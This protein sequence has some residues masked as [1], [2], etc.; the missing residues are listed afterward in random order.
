MKHARRSSFWTLLAW[1]LA[2]WIGSSVVAAQDSPPTVLLLPPADA[3]AEVLGRVGEPIELVVLKSRGDQPAVGEELTWTLEDAGSGQLEVLDRQSRAAADGVEA[4]S[5][6]AR[7]TALGPGRHGIR[8]Q[9][10]VEPGCTGSACRLVAHRFVVV[11][12]A[13]P[14]ADRA[15]PG[16]SALALVGGSVAALALMSSEGSEGGAPGARIGIVSGNGQAALANNPLPQPLVVES[17]DN[18]APA[19]NAVITWTASPGVVLSA[20]STATSSSGRTNV[21]V[22]SVGPGPGPATVTATRASDPSASVTFNIAVNIAGLAIVSGDN[23]TTPVDTTTAAPLVVRTT[24]DGS[25]QANVAL[26]WQIL[27]GGTLSG[28]VGTSDASGLAQAF[29]DVGSFPGPIT[30]LVSRVDAPSATQAFTVQAVELRDLVI[31]SGDGQSGAQG[32]PLPAPLA[33]QAL[34]NGVGDAGVTLFW[35]ASG[36]AILSATTTTTDAAGFSN[37]TVTDL[38]LGL[39]PVTVFV[40]RADV[41]SLSAEFTLNVLPPSLALVSGGGQSG[42]AG[43]PAAQPLQVLLLDGAGAPMAGQTVSWQLQ[44]GS[45]VLAAPFSVT[46][47]AGVATVGF[48]Y[49]NVPGPISIRA[50]AFSNGVVALASATGLPPGGMAAASGDGQAGD[51]GDVLAPLTV[52]IVDP[53]PDLSNIQITFV[54][55]SG[56]ATLAPAVALTDAAGQASTTVTLGT[57]PGPVVV[58]AIA[59]GGQVTIF[60]LTINGTLVVTGASTVSGDGQ[61]LAIGVASAPMVV[62]L[63]GNGVPLVGETVQWSTTN[64]TLANATTVTDAN[65]QTSNTVTISSAGAAKVI[66]SFPTVDEF[67]GTSVE[68]NHNGPLAVIPNLAINEASVAEALDAACGVLGGTAALTPDEQDLLDQCNALA[69]ASGTDPATVGPALTAMLPDV[70]QVQTDAGKAAVGAQFENLDGRI[71]QLRSGAPMAKVSF[72]GLN[73]AMSGGQVS[74]AQVGSL[75]MDADPADRPVQES[76]FS[77]WGFFVSGNIGRGESDPTILTPRYDFDINGLTAGLDYRWSDALVVGAALGYTRQDTELA[78]ALGS[79]DTQ[80]FSLSAYSTWYSQREWYLDSVLTLARNQ[81]DH[82]RSIRYTLPGM[83]VD[84]RATASSDGTD[85]SATLTFGRD[86]QRQAWSIGAYARAAYNRLSFDAF[87]ET[88]DSTQPGRGLALRVES[89]DVSGSSAIL[90]G[91][92]AYTHSASW[93]VLVPQL[94]VEWQNDFQSDTEAFRGYFLDDP[95]GTPIL[96]LGD[97]LDNNYLRIGLGLTFVLTEGRSGFI[98]YERL[99]GRSGISQEM[100]SL[101]FRWEF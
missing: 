98:N 94:D 84:Q 27:G 6:R 2:G 34:D 58:H 54:V 44:S 16:R 86:W 26:Q 66:A 12:Q 72:A 90:G 35:S 23:Q 74:L 53:A 33:V 22:L 8:V 50:S 56:S 65:G 38:G 59:P 100:L 81:Y 75:L 63:I 47:A 5:G 37:V 10:A 68:F 87:N 11:V 9:S 92:L 89:R 64:G 3:P 42:L 43:T 14:E 13:G 46:D 85:L 70:A 24:L 28:V 73:L 67:V 48:T 30:V 31:S 57:T 62:E 18:G 32:Q 41:P 36:G 96:V 20:A 61:D 21:S 4:G 1:V 71:V 101:G 55:A 78:N 39:A 83:V 19:G 45:A 95:T 25:P 69:A 91:K 99:A 7:F 51:P 88:V 17:R 49:G 60:N 82:E 52:Q 97:D 29:V 93:G 77:K 40:Y 79:V 76:E 80:G 15:G